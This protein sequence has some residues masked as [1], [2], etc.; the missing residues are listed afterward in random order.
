MYNKSLY[1][2]VS[3]QFPATYNMAG[4]AIKALSTWWQGDLTLIIDW[5]IVNGL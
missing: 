4:D 3:V 5:E 1:C 2:I